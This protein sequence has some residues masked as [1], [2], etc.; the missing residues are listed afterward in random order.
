MGCG[1]CVEKCP[2]GAIRLHWDRGKG[3]PLDLDLCRQAP[4]D[5]EES[6]QS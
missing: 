4:L 5:I 3:M 1:L 6:K 2:Q